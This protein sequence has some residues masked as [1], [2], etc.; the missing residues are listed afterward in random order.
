MQIAVVLVATERH[1][2]N[3]EYRLTPFTSIIVVPCKISMLKVSRS[4][5]D[6]L[7]CRLNNHTVSLDIGWAPD[8]HTKELL[9]PGTG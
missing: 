2:E 3:P 5:T 6:L 7:C 8:I 1:N 9:P 4:A